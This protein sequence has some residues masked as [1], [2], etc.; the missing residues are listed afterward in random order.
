M[1]P[2]THAVFLTAV[3]FAFASFLLPGSAGIVDA[4]N[5]EP[6]GTAL[7]HRERDHPWNRVHAALLM[8]VGLDGRTYGEDRLEPLLWNESEYL[9]EGKTAERAVAAL[10]EFLRGNGES[11][12][13][14]SVKRAVLQRDLWLV[15]NWAAGLSD[16]DAAGRLRASLAKVI[17]RLALSPDRIA[18]LPD[19]YAA[20]IASKKYADHFDPEQPERSYLPPDLFQPDGPWVC[21]GRTTGRTAPQHLDE[22]GGT[23][24][25][26]SAFLIFLK[27]P[28]G[29]GA[30]LDFLK[31]QA[32]FDGP[33]Y[34]ANPDERTKPKFPSLPNP[35]LPQWPKGT[36]VA[37]VRRAML[38]DSTGRVAASPLTESVQFRVM[39]TDT[40]A[41]TAE[42]LEAFARGA[43]DAQAFAEFQLR[44]VALFA[45][46]G[47]GLRDVSTERDFKTGF[48]AHPW[49][50]FVIRRAE[51]F[52][53][54]SWPFKNNRASCLGCH[55][56][57]GIYGFNSFHDDFPFGVSR[58][59]ADV[60]EGRNASA[61][62][63]L[64]P[65]PLE[66]VERAAV[67]WKE[68]QQA[69]KTL[70]KLMAE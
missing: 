17:P 35:D 38:I 13:E 42:A 46:D 4:T 16:T 21:I 45:G 51:E 69:W 12:I 19:N 28:A 29:R 50:E 41:M 60:R 26:N 52:P 25:T 57:P 8:R 9:L 31:R 6:A 64:G 48:R 43:S 47:G 61:S 23:R 20:A 11:R 32:A 65:M 49:D 15:F 27:F 30:V 59:P 39:R 66:K 68:E 1:F 10:D 37:L 14:D 53:E 67:N 18:Q 54:R 24:F 44:R 3:A 56:Y 33:L 22:G 2:R 70:R 55:P 36:E 58:K 7:Y 5:E 34:L 62:L 63:A 40:P